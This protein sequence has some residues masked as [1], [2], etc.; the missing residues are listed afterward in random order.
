M[1]LWKHSWPKSRK[2]D[3]RERDLRRLCT[4]YGYDVVQS[5]RGHFK[6][7]TGSGKVLATASVTSSDRNWL[8]AVE[9]NLQ[10]KR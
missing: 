6:I 2:M 9:R 8:R 3:K 4:R 7:L 10:G 1:P 5:K